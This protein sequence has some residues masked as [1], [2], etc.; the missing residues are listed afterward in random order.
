M[1]VQYVP[2]S[3]TIMFIDILINQAIVAVKKM[4]AKTFS[5]VHVVISKRAFSSFILQ[6]FIVNQEVK[7]NF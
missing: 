2:E 5:V 4:Y 1:F 7:Y 3:L 6:K